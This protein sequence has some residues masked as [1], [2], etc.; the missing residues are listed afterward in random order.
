MENFEE[1]QI[2][3]CW[4]ERSKK[5]VLHAFN[6]Q[7]QSSGPKHS[8]CWH[9]P[10]L[11]LF[12]SSVILPCG[13]RKPGVG[14]VSAEPTDHPSSSHL[15]SCHVVQGSLALVKW[16]PVI[17]SSAAPSVFIAFFLRS[18]TGCPVDP[19]LG[20][21]ALIIYCHQGTLPHPVSL[22][23]LSIAAAARWPLRQRSGLPSC[24]S[25]RNALSRRWASSEIQ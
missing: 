14:Q 9:L 15:W 19:E 1:V 12:D 7:S 8:F 5:A 21:L 23:P 13:L 11:L 6:Q 24:P 4:T 16:S 18:L 17:V 22:A 25:T 3:E 2:T 10:C 20:D